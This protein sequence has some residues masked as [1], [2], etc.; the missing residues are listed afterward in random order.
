[1]K[2]PGRTIHKPKKMCEK[3]QIKDNKNNYISPN[4]YESLVI[5]GSDDQIILLS[6]Q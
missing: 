1:M 3:N 2:F 4:K 5:N 6:T